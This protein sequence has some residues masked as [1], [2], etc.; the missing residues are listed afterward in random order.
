MA[1]ELYWDIQGPA[2]L[3][4][5]KNKIKKTSTHQ[6]KLYILTFQNSQT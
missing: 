2:V 5:P 1:K 4:L 6:I 3:K